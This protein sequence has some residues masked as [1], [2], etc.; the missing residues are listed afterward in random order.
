MLHFDCLRSLC[1]AADVLQNRVQNSTNNSGPLIKCIALE[2]AH[3]MRDK[4]YTMYVPGMSINELPMENNDGCLYAYPAIR[5]LPFHKFS[6]HDYMYIVGD[7]LTSYN[8]KRIDPIY[9]A[10]KIIK[11][12][13]M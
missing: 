8:K 10:M 3:Y 9:R 5:Q 13:A 6:R 7:A 4:A 1:I 12:C 11:D 2:L